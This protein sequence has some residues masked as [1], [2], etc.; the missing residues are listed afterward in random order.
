MIRSNAGGAPA[1]VV[2][3]ANLGRERAGSAHL[4]DPPQ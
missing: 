1:A 2:M 3:G 4:A